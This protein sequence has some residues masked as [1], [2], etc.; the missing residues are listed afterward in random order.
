ME[1]QT[2]EQEDHVHDVQAQGEAIL[3]EVVHNVAQDHGDD[4]QDLGVLHLLGGGV[5]GVRPLLL[6]HQQGGIHG[7]GV[8][9]VGMHGVVHQRHEDQD[10]AHHDKVHGMEN[11]GGDGRLIGHV[12]KG[13]AGHQIQRNGAGETCVPDNEAGVG[14]GDEQRI[15]HRGHTAH[16]FLGQQSADDQTEAPVQPAADGGLEGGDQN[17]LLVV[18]AQAGHGAQRLLAGTGRGHGGAEDQHQSHLH[19]K[20]QQTPKAALL[21]AP[22]GQN[23]DDT[24]LGGQQRT[25]KG[26][27]GQDDSEQEGVGQP[28]VDDSDAAIGEF[29]K[30]SVTLLFLH[31]KQFFLADLLDGVDN[32]L[33]Q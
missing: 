31:N 24:H 15:V 16:H 20:A 1:Q 8:L 33:T 9:L 14:G 6:V 21:V 10:H 3:H 28:S 7:D 29:L 22:S 2:Q 32:I 13:F 4:P 27:D 11:G 12:T 26:N 5:L 30:H 25:N 18:V 23:L 19:G 17:G